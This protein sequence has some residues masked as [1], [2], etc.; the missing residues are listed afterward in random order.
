MKPTDPDRPDGH[1]QQAGWSVDWIAQA[2]VGDELMA[3]LDRLERQRRERR[4][5]LVPVVALGGF[6]VA[7]SFFVLLTLHRPAE[8]PPLADAG[9]T[10]TVI[11]P[12]RLALPDGSVLEQREGAAVEMAYTPGE[13]RVVL[14]RGTA[15]FHVAKDATRPFV[16]EAGNL[17]VK[18]VGTVFSVERGERGIEVLVTEGRVAIGTSAK[19]SA[20]PSLDALALASVGAGEVAAVTGDVMSAPDVSVTKLTPSEVATRDEWRVP[21]LRFSA[22]P[23][24]EVIAEFN[25]R[26]R[27]QLVLADDSLAGLQLSGILRADNLDGLLARLRNDFGV[28]T[29]AAADGTIRLRARR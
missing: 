2:G 28:E 29:D 27:R 17:R 11:S 7:A 3:D 16:V 15:S 12:A 14:Q 9:S 10:V 6:A 18:A 4:R 1:P 21:R 19:F 8:A 20:D 22:T 24:I 23:L 5:R 26:N 13:R 25:E